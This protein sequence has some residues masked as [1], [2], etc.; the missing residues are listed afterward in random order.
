KSYEG[1]GH[2]LLFLFRCKKPIPALPPEIDEGGFGFFTR[3]AMDNI[4]IPATD[5]TALWPVFDNHRDRFVMLNV[6]C[7]PASPLRVVTEEII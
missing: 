7:N 3:A 6:D 4:N 5:R 2:W 1:S